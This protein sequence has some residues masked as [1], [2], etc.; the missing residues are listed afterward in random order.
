MNKYGVI[1]ISQLKETQRKIKN[2]HLKKYGVEHPMQNTQYFEKTQ[3]NNF[4]AKKYKNT[5][6]YY[7]GSYELDFL[8]KYYNKF[9]DIKNASSIKYMLNNKEHIYFPDFYIPSLNIIIE[10]KSSYY[11]KKY[12]DKCIAKQIA[13]ETQGFK[14][15]LIIDKNY[16]T[17]F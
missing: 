13:T 6:I 10:I 11:L 5:N 9:I 3:R 4:L 7:R 8:E 2:T 12:K 16:S 15:I 14:Y 17:F 1:N